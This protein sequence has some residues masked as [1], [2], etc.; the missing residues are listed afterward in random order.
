MKD[1]IKKILAKR[2][3]SLINDH[4]L[5]CEKLA[6]QSGVQKSTLSKIVNCKSQAQIIIISKLCAGLGISLTEFFDDIDF[7]K[8]IEKL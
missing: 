8:F 7:E 4:N 1:E 6:Y 2:I 5:S 3:I